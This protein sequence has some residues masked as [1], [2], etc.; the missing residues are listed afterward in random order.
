MKESP[1]NLAERLFQEGIR[2]NSYKATFF[3]EAVLVLDFD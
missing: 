1:E 2:N 3:G